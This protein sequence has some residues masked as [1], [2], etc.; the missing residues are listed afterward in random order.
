MKFILQFLLYIFLSIYCPVQ[1]KILEPKSKEFLMVLDEEGMSRIR[2]LFS[3]DIIDITC[4]YSDLKIYKLEIKNIV[5]EK[6]EN[7]IDTN[8]LFLIQTNINV[9]DVSRS[10]DPYY[11]L[12]SQFSQ[13]NPVVLD[14]DLDIDDAWK[15]TTD[16]ITSNGDTIVIAVIDEGVNKSHED[17]V[18][19]IWY[20]VNEIPNNNID[21]DINGYID[22]FWG[23]NTKEKNDNIEN[24]GIGNWHGT[25]IVGIIGA[26]GNN[27]IGIT[28]INRK[29]KIMNVVKGSDIA[30]IIEAYDYILKMRRLYNETEGRKGAFVVAINCSW[31]KEGLMAIDNPIWCLIYESL[32]KAGILTIVSAPN[33]NTDVD[34]INDMPSD[35]N[36]EYIISV[37]NTNKYDEKIF[38]AGFGKLNVDLGAPGENSFTTSNSGDYG[39]F[40]GTS[41]AAPYVSGAIGLLYAVDSYQLS[42]DI[43]KNPELVAINMKKYI[44]DGVIAIPDLKDRS[45]SSGRLNIM[46]SIFELS[47]DYQLKEPI[48]NEVF[49]VLNFENRNSLLGVYV[50][51]LLK[52]KSKVR[53]E[54]IDANGRHIYSS[55]EREL[56]SGIQGVE[57]G[58]NGLLSGIYSIKWMVKDRVYGTR[59]IKF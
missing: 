35:C 7:F 24:D 34:I 39:Y 57:I 21:D 20:N 59:I 6:F 3:N 37:T 27:E 32:G 15:Y 18:N 13:S 44:L 25:P 38:D 54:L 8:S 43:I 53:Y 58:E 19:S 11:Y 10:N 52:E 50:R 5:L 36:S 1:K 33:S 42:M 29:V 51:V 4:I 16:G 46:N 45:T 9:R 22:D 49:K 55:V 14:I 40:G 17:L 2:L 47:K 31:G 23:W 56:P 12:Q 41:A 28:G 30:S 26:K 48:N